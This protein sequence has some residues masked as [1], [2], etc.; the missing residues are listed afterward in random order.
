MLV[1][2]KTTGIFYRNNAT[3]KQLWTPMIHPAH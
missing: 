3:H 1:P 2:G